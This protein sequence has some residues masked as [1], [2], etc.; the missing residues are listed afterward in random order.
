LTTGMVH[1]IDAAQ[2]LSNNPMFQGVTV[3]NCQPAKLEVLV[4]E[5]EERDLEV[6]PPPGITNLVGPPVFT[7]RSVKVRGPKESLEELDKA[8][9]L[10]AIADLGAF[11]AMNVPGPHDFP[12]VRIKPLDDPSVVF[13]PPN[14]EAAVSVRESDVPGTIRSVPIWVSGPPALLARYHVELVNPSNGVLTNVKVIGPKD[15]IDLVNQPDFAKPHAVLEIHDEDESSSG[16]LLQRAVRFDLG[17]LG[18]RVNDEIS[19]H[20]VD[21]RLVDLKTTE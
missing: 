1:E 8:H 2:A 15:K 9:K 3:S 4:D 19:Q 11:D 16:K 5:V 18:L 20:P 10:V 17:D 12:V 6:Q 7:P 13:T 21:F 14:V